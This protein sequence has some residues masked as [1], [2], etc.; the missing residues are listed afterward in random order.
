MVYI[1]FGGTYE[2]AAAPEAETSIAAIASE[3][4]DAG[5]ARRNEKASGSYAES[6]DYFPAGYVNRGRDG[7]GNVVTYDH[8]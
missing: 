8:D 3:L 7:D 4:A 5:A 1:V 2:V 6:N